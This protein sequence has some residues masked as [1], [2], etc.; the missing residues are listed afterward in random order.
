MP[1]KPTSRSFQWSVFLTEVSFLKQ[2]YLVSGWQTSKQHT[3]KKSNVNI[4]IAII[5]DKQKVHMILIKYMSDKF[6]M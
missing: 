6:V 3:Q 2:L 5:F 4:Y 1:H